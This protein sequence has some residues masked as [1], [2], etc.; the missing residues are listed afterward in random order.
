MLTGTALAGLLFALHFAHVT[1]GLDLKDFTPQ[2]TE[3]FMFS[4]KRTF[5]YGLVF[6]LLAVIV[7]WM[8]GDVAQ[9]K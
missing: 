3:A 9:V 2:V 4:L 7:S 8:R 1:G 6:S 5:Q